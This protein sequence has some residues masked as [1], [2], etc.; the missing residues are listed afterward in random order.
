MMCSQKKEAQIRIEQTHM[1]ELL[2]EI[3]RRKRAEKRLRKLNDC[4]LS[5]GIDPTENI[6]SLTKLAG[7]ML[8]T[9]GTI[10]TSVNK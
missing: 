7:E 4:F 1:K 3:E 8:R 2:K 6:N 5:F 9:I 10:G